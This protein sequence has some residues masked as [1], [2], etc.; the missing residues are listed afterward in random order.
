MKLLSKPITVV[1]VSLIVIVGGYKLINYLISQSRDSL[2]MYAPQIK[3]VKLYFVNQNG[4]FQVEKREIQGGVSVMEDVRI[5]IDELAV[6]PKENGLYRGFPAAVIL[7][8]IYIDDN[9]CIYL[10]FGKSIVEKQQG[11]T[12]RELQMIYSL[13]NTILDN[14]GQVT[15]VRILVEGQEVKTIGGHLDINQPLRS[16]KLE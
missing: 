1:L 8:G 5:C 13:V 12:T 2:F 14:F 11:G 9:R 16:K 10:D 7:N 3:K 4:K 15:S 6:G